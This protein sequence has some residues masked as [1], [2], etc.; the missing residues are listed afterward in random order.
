M[1]L[2][3][4]HNA[5]AGPSTSKSAAAG[6]G[7]VST[8]S[9]PSEFIKKLYKM[10]EEEAATYGKGFAPGQPRGPNAQ[11]GSVGWARGGTTFVVWEMNIF[12][13]KVL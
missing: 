9:A 8:S 6:N 12:T 1:P 4:N 5:S 3:S 10:L 7:E 13:T 11:R 2:N